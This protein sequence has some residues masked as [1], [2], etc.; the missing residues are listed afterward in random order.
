MWSSSD[1]AVLEIWSEDPLDSLRGYRY[2]I[3]FNL[4]RFRGIK[5]FYFSE[6][7][8]NLVKLDAKKFYEERLCFVVKKKFQDLQVEKYSFCKKPSRSQSQLEEVNQL[9]Y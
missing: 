1:R 5:N 8:L 9:Q 2:H 6:T 4:L 3:S 7:Q